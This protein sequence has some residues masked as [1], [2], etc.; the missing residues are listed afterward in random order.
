MC[1]LQGRGRNKRKSAYMTFD[2]QQ[3]LACFSIRYTLPPSLV[4]H[5]HSFGLVPTASLDG[6]KNK[7]RV[8]ICLCSVPKMSG[9]YIV[10]TTVLSHNIILDH[11]VIDAATLA[12]TETKFFP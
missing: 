9:S 7:V 5:M 12:Y 10:S 11:E 2:Y 1:S 8:L 6:V 4:Y 3:T